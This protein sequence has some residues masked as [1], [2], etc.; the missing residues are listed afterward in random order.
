MYTLNKVV[1]TT[2]P[3]F[4]LAGSI[5]SNRVC[6]GIRASYLTLT[7][8]RVHTRFLFNWECV[9]ILRRDLNVAFID[10]WILDPADLRRP[11]DILA[12]QTRCAATQD[13]DRTCV[14]PVCA[15]VSTLQR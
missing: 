12:G 13:L 6:R 8:R 3:C 5:V 7:T 15:I 4:Q 14:A 10:I 9:T 11:W 2:S 1:G